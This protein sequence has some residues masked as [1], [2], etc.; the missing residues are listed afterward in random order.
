MTNA[1]DFDWFA[2]TSRTY[3]IWTSFTVGVHVWL[4]W[5][6]STISTGEGES[7]F[8]GAKLY[9]GA[10]NGD[11]SDIVENNDYEVVEAQNIPD[12]IKEKVRQMAA[13]DSE[14]ADDVTEIGKNVK[15]LDD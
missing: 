5:E 7:Y 3:T 12:V 4:V 6:V 15:D 2:Q 1:Q 11:E 9:A 10:G 13:Q 14:C 8:A